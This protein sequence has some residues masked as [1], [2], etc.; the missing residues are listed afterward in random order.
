M[1]TVL[2]VDDALTDLKTHTSYL[3]QAGL[4]VISATSVEEA[5]EK[6]NQNKPDLILLDIILPGQSGYE[7]CKDLKDNPETKDIPVILC[8]TKNTD[9]DKMW[10][11][12]LGAEAYLTKPVAQAD[13]LGKVKQLIHN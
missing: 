13:L 5:R 6:L 9:A 4:K 7:L 3:Q 10:G 8:S 2:V 12:M 1:S 11:D